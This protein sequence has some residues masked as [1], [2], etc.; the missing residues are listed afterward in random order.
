MGPQLGDDEADFLFNDRRAARPKLRGTIAR[1]E[2]FANSEMLTGIS[3]DNTVPNT[4][5][6]PTLAD[7]MQD[8]VA[9]NQDSG[10]EET[11]SQDPALVEPK[12]G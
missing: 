9:G 8:N 12:V 10:N 5:A 7:P 2:L 11:A 4:N 1:G 3:K 6:I